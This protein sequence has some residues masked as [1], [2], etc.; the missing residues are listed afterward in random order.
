MVF[1]AKAR[2]MAVLGRD[3]VMRSMDGTAVCPTGNAKSDIVPK[4]DAMR[5]TPLDPRALFEVL[6]CL[7]DMK[8]V[9]SLAVLAWQRATCPIRPWSSGRLQRGWDQS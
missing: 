4:R 6:N 3:G 2:R 5:S 9:F 1:S 8:W 7:E